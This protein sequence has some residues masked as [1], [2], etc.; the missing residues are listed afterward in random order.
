MYEFVQDS[1]N[2]SS[3]GRQSLPVDLLLHL[4]QTNQA[5]TQFRIVTKRKSKRLVEIARA[6]VEAFVPFDLG[7]AERMEIFQ[8]IL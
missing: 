4:E 6:R 5:F 3:G 2:G 8:A 7:Q 1:Q